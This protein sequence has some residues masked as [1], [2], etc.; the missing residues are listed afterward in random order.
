MLRARNCGNRDFIVSQLADG[1]MAR[2][3][4]AD[5]ASVTAGFA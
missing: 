3:P 4:L 2:L 5:P 1:G